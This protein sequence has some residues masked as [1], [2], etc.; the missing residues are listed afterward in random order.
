MRWGKVQ[1]ASVLFGLL[2]CTSAFAQPVIRPRS[3]EATFSPNDAL[4]RSVARFAVASTELK[5]QDAQL[6]QADLFGL[7]IVLSLSKKHP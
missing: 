7:M 3:I 2:F 1:T 5:P 6:S 4:S